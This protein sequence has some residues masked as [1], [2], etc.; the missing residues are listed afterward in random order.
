MLVEVIERHDLESFISLRLLGVV[1]HVQS[2]RLL[3][4]RFI[5]IWQFRDAGLQSL[6]WN[7]MKTSWKSSILWMEGTTRLPRLW[8]TVFHQSSIRRRNRV[9]M[10]TLDMVG[11]IHPRDFVTGWLLRSWNCLI[12]SRC[13]IS[14]IR[15]VFQ[16][17]M[18][19][20]LLIKHMIRMF[21]FNGLKM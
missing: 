21:W 4:T 2:T 9:W 8:Q 17:M 18:S 14:L 20:K 1:L 19:V 12:L 3:F 5:T 6:I 7:M 13:E 10:E 15:D 16:Y 11:I